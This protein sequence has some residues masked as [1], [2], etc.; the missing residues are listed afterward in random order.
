MN[1]GPGT[2]SWLSPPEPRTPH[3]RR[4][5]QTLTV[6]IERDEPLCGEPRSDDETHEYEVEVDFDDG[7]V[8]SAAIVSRSTG[9][10]VSVDVS[11]PVAVEL[12]PREC[13][14]AEVDYSDD[15]IAREESAREDAADRERDR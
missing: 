12:T 4:A 8:Y 14:C 5:R 15:L 9:N 2:D 10:A 1:T 13:E 7:S 6:Y 3:G 11:P